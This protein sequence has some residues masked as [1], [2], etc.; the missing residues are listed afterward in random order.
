MADTHDHSVPHS[1]GDGAPHSHGVTGAPHAHRGNG[2]AHSHGDDG[3]GHDGHPDMF[4]MYMVIAVALRKGCQ[5]LSA[6]TL[7]NRRPAK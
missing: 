5:S 6:P 2:V 4:K 3:Q 7:A 1:H